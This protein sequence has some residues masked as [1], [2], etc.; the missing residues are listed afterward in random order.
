MFQVPESDLPAY[1]FREKTYNR[2]RVTRYRGLPGPDGK[3]P[4]LP[5][6]AAVWIYV[7]PAPK[8]PTIHYPILQTY[9]DVIVAGALEHSEEFARSVI[10]TMSGFENPWKNDRGTGDPSSEGYFPQYK[11]FSEKST[12]QAARIDQL[13]Q[14]E[15]SAHVAASYLSTGPS[16]VVLDDGIP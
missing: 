15:V 8:H 16:G 6:N 14:E 5:P 13:L 2:T 10:C 4:E 12:S 1:D 11:R 3:Q 9:V 7:D